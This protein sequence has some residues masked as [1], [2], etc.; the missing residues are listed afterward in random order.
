MDGWAWTFSSG[1]EWGQVSG[2]F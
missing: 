2:F 1:S